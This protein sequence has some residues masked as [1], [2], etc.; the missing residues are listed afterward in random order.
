M[1]TKIVKSYVDAKKKFGAKRPRSA[2]GSATNLIRS[3]R[4]NP[5]VAN[6]Q[7]VT[8]SDYDKVRAAVL[9]RTVP[10]KPTPPPLH[11]DSVLVGEELSGDQDVADVLMLDDDE[12]EELEIEMDH[13]PGDVN[14]ENPPHKTPSR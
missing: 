2:A 14:K 4:M 6:P 1:R 3:M 12:G 8:N 11:N 9:S 13:D 7:N 10:P 5:P